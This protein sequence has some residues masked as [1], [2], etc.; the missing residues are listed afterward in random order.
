LRHCGA[1]ARDRA[2]SIEIPQVN[3]G[4]TLDTQVLNEGGLMRQSALL[5]ESQRR[6]MPVGRFNPSLG[7]GSIKFGQVLA[8]K[9]LR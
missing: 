9:M 5:Q 3:D 2:I 6:V 8:S 1:S 4:P 7:N